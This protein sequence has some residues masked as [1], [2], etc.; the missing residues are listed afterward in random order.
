MQREGEVVHV[1]AHRLLDFSDDLRRVGNTD[2]GFSLTRGRGDGATHGGGPD[3]RDLPAPHGRAKPRDIYIPD[4]AL[5]SGIKVPTR[6][7]R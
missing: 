4:L 3:A 7:F 5:G 2:G 6:D 1:I